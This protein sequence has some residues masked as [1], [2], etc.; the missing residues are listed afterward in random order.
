LVFK[1]SVFVIFIFLICSCNQGSKVPGNI[2]LGGSAIAPTPPPT[3]NPIIQISWTADLGEQ[4]GFYIEQ[5]SDGVTFNQV[6]IVPD[7]TYSATL[8]GFTPA[9][10]YYFRIR[11]YDQSG[12]SPYSPVVSLTAS[13]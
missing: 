8:T 11:A 10:T 5:S 13:F 12:P 7:G 9:A 3:G 6:Q 1:I 4:Q 2:T